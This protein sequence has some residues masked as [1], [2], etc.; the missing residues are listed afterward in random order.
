MP[1]NI[2]I[3]DK[4]ESIRMQLRRGIKPVEFAELDAESDTISM[5]DAKLLADHLQSSSKI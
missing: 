4:F 3:T 1:G 5:E 2:D